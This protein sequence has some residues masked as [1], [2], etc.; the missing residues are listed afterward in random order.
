MILIPVDLAF[1]L[2]IDDDTRT[3]KEQQVPSRLVVKLKQSVTPH[4]S[5]GETGIPRIG[6]ADFDALNSKF[7]ARQQSRLFARGGHGVEG[8]RL[9]NIFVIDFETG[10][11]VE[12]MKA[13]YEG[14]ES[15]VYAQPDYSVE[16]YDTPNDSLYPHQWALNNTGQGYYHVERYPGLYN[17]SLIIA[18]GTPDAD[19]DAEEV[20]QNPPDNTTTVI[21]AMIDT[22]VDLD[23]QDLAA[24]IWTNDDE[25]PDN[26]IDDDRNG[27]TDD[28]IGWDFAGDDQFDMPDNDPTDGYGHGSHCAGIIAAVTD[29][30]SGVAGIAQ[31][32]KIMALKFYPQ[33]ITTW[34]AEAIVYAADNGADVISMSWGLPYAIPIWEDALDYARAKGVILVAAAGND[35][36][37]QVN[38]P[39]GYDNNI[40]VAASNSDDLMT[41]FSTFGPQITVAAPGQSILSLRA[42]QKDM[43]ASSYE[44]DVHIIDEY[45]YLASGTSMAAPQV[46]G[47]AAYMRSV[48]AG[49][50]PDKAQEII[51][52]T[53]DDYLDPFGTGENLPG[54]DKY[55]GYGRVNLNNALAAVPDIRAKITSPSLSEL[56]A[57]MVDIFGIADGAE[58]TGYT[59]EY[60]QGS[61]P[62]SWTEIVSSTTPVTD[63][64][65]AS[66]NT[67]GLS[68]T[69]TIRLR[70]GEFNSSMV[71]LFLTNETTVDLMLPNEGDTI[72]YYTPIIGTA[73]CPDFEKVRLEWGFGLD[74]TNWGI[75]AE[76]SVPMHESELTT[77]QASDLVADRTYT[78]RLSVFSGSGI[79]GSDIVHVYVTSPFTGTHGWRTTIGDT[80]GITPNWGDFDGDGQNE[81]IVGARNGL[82]FFNTDGTQKTEGVPDWSNLDFRIQTPV[83]N[84]DGD[85]I[86]D[87]A[88]ISVEPGKL[89]CYWSSGPRFVVDLPAEPDFDNYASTDEHYFPRLFL[90]DIDNDGIDE[91]H[92]SAGWIDPDYYIFNADGTPWD[93]AFPIASTRNHFLPVD[94]DGDS[95]CEIYYNNTANQLIQLDL[96]GNEIN[97]FEITDVL[98][99]RADLIS[100]VDIDHDLKP[101]LIMFGAYQPASGDKAT[102]YIYAFDEDLSLISGWPHDTGIDDFYL[103]KPPIFGDLN[104]DGRL[105][106][107]TTF[108]DFSGGFVHVWDL[109]GRPFMGDSTLNGLF[110]GTPAD[111]MPQIPVLAD[112][113]GDRNPDIVAIMS[114]ALLSWETRQGIDAWQSDGSTVDGYPIII[115][116]GL[117]RSYRR[118]HTPVIGDINGDGMLDMMLTTGMTELIFTEFDDVPYVPFYA[119]CPQYRYNRA[120]D[121]TY[122][123]VGP[124]ME[125]GNADGYSGV[126]IDDIVYL[127]AYIF[128]NGPAP[129]SDQGGDPDCSGAPDID[130]VVYIIGYVFAA[131]PAPCDINGDGEPDCWTR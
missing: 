77:L 55:S 111:F 36:Y 88:A 71:T 58:F 60:G 130:D 108:Y 42:D 16:L 75:L 10:T 39:A 29:N 127:I 117:S 41:E 31:N 22:G 129:L 80:V 124:V 66:W 45:Y 114:P 93:C 7:Q 63:G 32:C 123:N 98:S 40:A 74:P 101:E 73:I 121:N 24:N 5:A 115:C 46:A 85:G 33:M 56:A 1:G 51:Q 119:P 62:S 4:L 103:P 122:M 50:S 14:L 8:D 83:G 99:F 12:K 27:Y 28:W 59:L 3:H 18:Y 38:F 110:S 34:A 78:L 95:I 20:F 15:V 113:S 9:K 126:D 125:C 76:S 65:L 64:V 94:M 48:S 118:A 26:G 47:V 54:W 131:G 30:Q 57:G 72:V 104:N 90:K 105:E 120:M 102:Y 17:D 61:L 23:H 53:A 86:D 2:Y 100:A 97:R 13:E 92:Y 43:Y 37:E 68:G 81:I 69:Y 109:D 19:I 106:Y 35:G 89:Y 11:D 112:I 91:I 116:G 52:Q 67:L 82:W 96:C 6:V 25:I 79:E 84:L 21:V 128:S 107:V 44:P 49:L 70:V 87:F